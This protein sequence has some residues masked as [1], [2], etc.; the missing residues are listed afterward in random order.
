MGSVIVL[1]SI[2]IDILLQVE[3]LPTAG[4]TV[5][6]VALERQLGGKGAN[7]AVGAARAGAPTM[8]LAAAGR[9]DEADRLLARL[10]DFGVGVKHVRRV[11]APTGLAVVVTSP[12]DNQIVVTAGAN[13]EVT[14]D[15]AAALPVVLGDVCLTQLETPVVA[16]EALFRSARA[17]GATTVLNPSP[18][19]REAAV[20]LPLTDV[21]VVN[22]SELDLLAGSDTLPADPDRRLLQQAE[23]LGA[24]RGLCLVV[25]L[26]SRGLAV[27]RDGAV[28][29]IAGRPARVVDTTGAGDCFCGYLCA[30]LA[31]WP[32]GRASS[33]AP[34]RP[35]RPRRCPS[36]L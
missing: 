26:G 22:E 30:A 3:R 13:A 21:L 27:V 12:L 24:G 29:R 18:V 6:G 5:H 7:Q 34:A 32:A 15:M 9:D 36:S 23:A 16:A 28:E 20:L 19:S 4:E 11:A 17:K 14:A 8:L 25:T 35:T 1:G 31:P 10:A 2:N 33:P